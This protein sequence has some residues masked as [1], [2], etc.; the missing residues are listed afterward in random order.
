MQSAQALHS[1]ADGDGGGEDGV[2]VHC[3][4]SLFQFDLFTLPQDF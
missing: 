3:S 4:L 1:V 2:Q